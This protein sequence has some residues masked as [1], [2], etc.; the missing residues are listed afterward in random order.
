MEIAPDTA[1]LEF[2]VVGN[3]F[4]NIKAALKSFVARERELQ[5]FITPSIID[6]Q[7]I[8]DAIFNNDRKELPDFARNAIEKTYDVLIRTRDGQLADIMLD[9]MALDCMA[10]F[11]AKTGSRFII[12]LVELISA[13]ANLRIALRAARTGKGREFLTDALC[14]TKTLSKNELI[15]ATLKG[16][17]ELKAFISG[18]AYGGAVEHI[19]KSAAAFEKW[20]DDLIISHISPAKYKSFGIDPLVAYFFAKQAEIKSVR[21]IISCKQIEL[22]AEAIRERV[23]E[24]Y[25]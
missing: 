6:P 20:C 14:S 17:G 23:R 19:Q 22:P 15:T 5:S 2:L 3:D 11:A 18:T 10:Q 12:D 9:A 24:I 21:I 25:V 7:E 16:E 8:K 13:T 4:H 1:E